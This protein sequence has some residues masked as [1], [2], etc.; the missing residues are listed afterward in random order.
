[1]CWCLP[2]RASAADDKTAKINR[3]RSGVQVPEVSLVLSF[4]A[5]R[6]SLYE[7]MK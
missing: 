4:S 3:A 2:S 5:V 7:L 1:M 6:E